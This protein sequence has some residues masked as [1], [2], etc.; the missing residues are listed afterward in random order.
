MLCPKC[1]FDDTAP[2]LGI[3][4]FF[5]DKPAAS[6]NDRHVNAGGGR[7]GY[8]KERNAWS[9]L[10]AAAK[11][12]H[13][14][15]EP[16]NRCRVTLTRVYSGRQRALDTDNLAGMKPLLDALVRA[17]LLRGDGPKDAEVHYRQEKRDRRGVAVMIEEF[18]P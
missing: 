12:R 9:W 1:G 8:A 2:I 13:H 17:K 16:R 7:W 6:L 14:L 3:V 4:E 5:L 11:L 10:V 18:A 15:I